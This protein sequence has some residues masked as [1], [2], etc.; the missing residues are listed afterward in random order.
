MSVGYEGSVWSYTSN[1]AGNH[2]RSVYLLFDVPR[3][4]PVF[5]YYRGYGFP[6]RCLSE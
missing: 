1:N 4:D 5:A 6:L 2:Y 3:L